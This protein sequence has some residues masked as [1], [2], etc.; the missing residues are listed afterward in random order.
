MATQTLSATELMNRIQPLLSTGRIAHAEID[1]S[2]DDAPRL[3]VEFILT[4]ELIEA[5]AKEGG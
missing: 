4:Q 5:M 2:I 3:K 1:L